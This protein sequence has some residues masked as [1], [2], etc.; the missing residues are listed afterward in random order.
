GVLAL[1]ILCY[2]NPW[3]NAEP[4]GT[5]KPPDDP[6]DFARFASSAAS[7]FAGRLATYEVWNEQNLGFRFWF[8]RE[9][10]DAYGTLLKATSKALRSADPNARVALGGLI[11]HGLFTTAER[12]LETVYTAHPDIAAAYDVLAFH[13]YPIYPPS[14]APEV[15]D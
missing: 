11:Y 13:P 5:I 9:D 14:V 4:M 8:P 10:G 3:A 15:D 6:A 12:F 2:G 1:P 7:A